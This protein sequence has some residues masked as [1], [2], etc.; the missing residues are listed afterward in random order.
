MISVVDEGD[1]FIVIESVRGK[2]TRTRVDIED[3][4]RSLDVIRNIDESEYK[5]GAIPCRRIAGDICK[6]V[7]ELRDEY[8]SHGEFIWS[9]FFGTRND[10]FKY[11]LSL[12]HI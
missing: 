12:I 11:Y 9:K 5:N 3:V 7:P 8:F 4:N 2:P 10:Y 1:Y 6:R